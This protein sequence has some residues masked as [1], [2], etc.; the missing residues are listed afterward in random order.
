MVAL[1]AVGEVGEGVGGRGS[2]L[3]GSTLRRQ[4]R[5][6]EG[7]WGVGAMEKGME[8]KLPGWRRALL[9]Q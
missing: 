7:G 9:R 6:Y 3:E 4:C 5:K 1:G 8:G 2:C